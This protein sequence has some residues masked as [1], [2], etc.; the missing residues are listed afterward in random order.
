MSL[1]EAMS[2]GMTREMFKL[3]DADGNG[4]ITKEE[5]REFQQNGPKGGELSI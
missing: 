2:Q 5:F 3:V 1:E 4:Q